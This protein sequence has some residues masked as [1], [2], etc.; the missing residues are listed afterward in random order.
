[1]LFEDELKRT[2][3]LNGTFTNHIWIK[4]S[5][6]KKNLKIPKQDKTD[7]IMFTHSLGEKYPSNDIYVAL[8][9]HECDRYPEQRT[10][11]TYIDHN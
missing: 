8:A 9:V 1:M 3:T 6:N 4:K 11:M 10:Q 5:M 2:M 7:E